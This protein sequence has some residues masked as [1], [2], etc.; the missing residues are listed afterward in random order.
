VLAIGTHSGQLIVV[1]V[2][3]SRSG[4]GGGAFVIASTALNSDDAHRDAIT[5]IA[6]IGKGNALDLATASNDGKVILWSIGPANLT[7]MPT[8]S[9]ATAPSATA[10]AQQG[11]QSI[12]PLRAIVVGSGGGS[13]LG[14]AVPGLTS[15]SWFLGGETSLQFVAG[16]EGGKL[17]KCSAESTAVSS[18][19]FSYEAHAGPVQAVSA[20]PFHRNVFASASTDG[21]LRLYNALSARSVL[22]FVPGDEPPLCV[23]WSP[24]RPSVLVAGCADGR[25]YF[26]DLAAP[27]GQVRPVSSLRSGGQ[28]DSPVTAMAMNK[29]LRKHAATGHIDGTV[30]VW[31]LATSLHQRTPADAAALEKFGDIAKAK[32]ATKLAQ[33]QASGAIPSP[34]IIITKS[35]SPQEIALVSGPS[36]PQSKSPSPPPV[37]PRPGTAMKKR[38]T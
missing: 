4:S 6:W 31:T 17:F 16:T 19:S 27:Q 2:D 8:T 25:M 1:D 20:S 26:Y 21:S 14:A 36:P 13:G 23:T 29:A 3:K 38:T 7:A 34:A 24:S 32:K 11:Q 33:K 18:V 37:K 12:K 5:N 22:T 28:S 30:R 10:S 15:F 9:V 35:T